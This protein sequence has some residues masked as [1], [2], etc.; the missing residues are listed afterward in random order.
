LPARKTAHH[1]RGVAASSND[2]RKQFAA[3]VQQ[4]ISPQK[5]K[6]EAQALKLRYL[7]FWPKAF[8]IVA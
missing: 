7:I 3:H 6:L 4:I 8:I 1:S 2:P 5:Y